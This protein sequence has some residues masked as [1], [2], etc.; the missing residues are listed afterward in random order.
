MNQPPNRHRPRVPKEISEYRM[1]VMQ[2]AR[3][4]TNLSQRDFSVKIGRAYA[5]VRA[6]ETRYFHTTI[7]DITTWA[8]G[9]DMD[10]VVLFTLLI[11]EP[12]QVESN[13]DG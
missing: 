2:E 5:F 10:P 4:S 12:E 1:K 7:E 8:K 3:K 11:K 13:G 9:C 6:R